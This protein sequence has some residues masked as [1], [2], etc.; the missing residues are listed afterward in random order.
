MIWQENLV[1]VCF[2]IK[3]KFR[4]RYLTLILQNKK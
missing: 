4:K 2:V 1:D 3:E